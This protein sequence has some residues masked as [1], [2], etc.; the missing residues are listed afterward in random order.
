MIQFVARQL[1]IKLDLVGKARLVL[2]L[3]ARVLAFYLHLKDE[4]DEG[5]ILGRMINAEM[6]MWMM[7]HLRKL[8]LNRDDI[9][10]MCACKYE[11]M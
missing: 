7:I 5:K 9:Y 11:F 3:P 2:D 1:V 4:Y 8:M 6:I 10:C